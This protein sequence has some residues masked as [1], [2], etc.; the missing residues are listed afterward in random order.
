MIRRP[1]RST[2]FPYTT[3]FRSGDPGLPHRAR[4][5]RRLRRRALQP[6]APLRAARRSGG[7]AAP[8]AHVSQAGAGVIHVGTSGYNYE[9]WRGS[10]YPEEL[11]S[12]RMLSYY[13]ERFDTVEINYSFYRKPT[14][15]I[16]Q[17]WASQVPER[18]LFA[19]KA[20]Q[21]ITPR[22]L[23]LESAEAVPA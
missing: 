8:P 1:P 18:F 17:N 23:L 13:G 16:L 5:R 15:K 6:G 22:K 11:P 10:F 3:L 2:L 4:R 21:R 20:W 12:R 9:A 19:L 7:R 14:P